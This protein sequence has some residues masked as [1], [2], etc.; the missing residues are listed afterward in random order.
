V[1]NVKLDSRELGAVMSH[2]DKDGS[3]EVDCAEFLLEFFKLG[4]GLGVKYRW[5]MNRNG[6][7]TGIWRHTD[8]E[9]MH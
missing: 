9:A 5:P 2:F 1:F 4:T 6:G 8:L 3:G 7:D